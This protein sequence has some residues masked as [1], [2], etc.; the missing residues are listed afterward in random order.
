MDVDL[1]AAPLTGEDVRQMRRALE[2]IADRDSWVGD[3]HLNS[4]FL[5]GPY[6]PFELANVALG[7]SA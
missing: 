7:R 2:V 5:N 4:S 3:P 6:T 1:Q